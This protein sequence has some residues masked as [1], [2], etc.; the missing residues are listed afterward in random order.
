MLIIPSIDIRNGR[1]VRLVQ[2]DVRQERVYADDLVAVATRW[3]REGARWLHVVDLDGALAG[4]PV[5]LD[6][7]RAIADTAGVPVQVGG[8]FRTVEDIEAGLA[9][10][11]ARVIVGTSAVALSAKLAPRYG[12]RLA[13]SLD[14]KEGRVAVKGWTEVTSFD[15]IALGRTL[16]AQGVA[17]FI[18]TNVSRDG[19]LAGPDVDGV[20]AFTRAVGIPVIAAGGIASHDDVITLATL[21]VE[22]VIVG[23]ALYDGRVN[24]ASLLAR[25]G[26]PAC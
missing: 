12:T 21:G 23:R 22:G 9:A 14:V 20:R 2:G 19:T 25:W 26:A 18:L 13:V 1:C 3:I 4:R 8:G 10:G 6:L 24:L 11:A 15:P 16:A 17:R 7:L 5:H